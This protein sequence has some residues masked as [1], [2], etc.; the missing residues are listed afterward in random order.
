MHVH[1]TKTPIALL[2]RTLQAFPG[3]TPFKVGLYLCQFGEGVVPVLEAE[4]EH[5][6]VSDPYRENSFISHHQ[7]LAVGHYVHQIAAVKLYPLVTV[8]NC[9]FVQRTHAIIEL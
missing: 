8:G 5:F 1:H 3:C 4:E 7:V 9:S 6:S 2:P